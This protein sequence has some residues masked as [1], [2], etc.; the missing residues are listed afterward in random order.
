MYKTIVGLTMQYTPLAAVKHRVVLGQALPFNVLDASHALMLAKG[1]VVQTAPQLE[2]LF[3]RGALVDLAELQSPA[4]RIRRVPRGALPDLWRSCVGD[5]YQALEQCSDEHFPEAI[6]Q[7]SQPVLALVERDPDLAIFQVLRQEANPLAQYGL[8]H[9]LHTGITC[10]LVARRLGWSDAEQERAMKV[11]L[12]M[13]V[14]VFELQGQLATQT[15]PITP[16]QRQAVLAHPEFSARMLM[17][18]GVTDTDWIKAVLWHHEVSDGS[19]YPRG[20][21]GTSDLANLVRQADIYTTKLSRRA[22]RKAVAPDEAARMVFMQDPQNSMINA[23]VKEFGLYPPG[24]FVRLVGGETG[25]VAQ[26]GVSVKFPIV[27]V[28]SDAHG[29]PLPQPLRCDTSQPGRGVVATLGEDPGLARF[30]MSQLL[31]I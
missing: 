20:L 25:V 7:A 3:E 1:Q 22:N 16:E 11:A 9:A 8:D 30:S 6:A 10:A 26:R 13:N 31:T 12:T 2:R 21:R 5:L 29:K 17:L 28:L 18:A 24:T 4:E 19:G 14:S 23:I 15:T 27:A